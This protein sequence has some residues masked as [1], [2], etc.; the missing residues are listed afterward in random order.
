MDSSLPGDDPEALAAYYVDYL[1]LMHHWHDVLPG[2]MMEVTY[3][4]LVDK[5]EMILRVVC[6]FLGI[7]YASSLRLGLQLHQR[8]QAP[9]HGG[10]LHDLGHRQRPAQHALLTVTE[11][12]PSAQLTKDRIEKICICSP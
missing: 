4:S 9:G 7:R 12:L 1:R 10:D 3:E 2:R 6:S 8:S 11:P 5:P